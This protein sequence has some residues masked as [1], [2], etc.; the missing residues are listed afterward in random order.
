MTTGQ[1][2]GTTA[3]TKDSDGPGRSDCKIHLA[4]EGEC[5]P[6]AFLL[7]PGQAPRRRKAY[8]SCHSRRNE[9]KRAYVFHHVT[10]A[11]MRLWLRT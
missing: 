7:T 2:P 6:M 5:R 11:A 4:G 10:V 9:D 1:R 3:P 8:S